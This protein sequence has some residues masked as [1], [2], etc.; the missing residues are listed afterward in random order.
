M[1]FC[2]P[3]RDVIGVIAAEC[4]LVENTSVSAVDD[5]RVVVNTSHQT[6]ARV[7]SGQWVTRERCE[8]AG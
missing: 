8:L 7:W 6:A 4:V 5:A 1:V 3:F 2:L